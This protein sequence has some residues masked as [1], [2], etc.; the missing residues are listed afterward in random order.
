[1]RYSVTYDD[2]VAKWVVIDMK[3]DKQQ[4][5]LVD[6]MAEAQR[7]AWL[8]EE[9]WHKCTPDSEIYRQPAV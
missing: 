2:L 3:R 7:A 6:T 4:V 5:A 9:R 8:E 1:M